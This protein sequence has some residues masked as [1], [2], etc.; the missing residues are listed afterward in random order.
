[1]NFLSKKSVLITGGGSGIGASFA[2]KF[3]SLQCK[4]WVVGRN[5][6]KLK[7]V[8]NLDENI[9]YF[10]CDVTDENQIIDLYDKIGSPDIIIANAGKAESSAFHKTTLNQCQNI[11]DVNLKWVLLE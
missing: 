4:V 5:K 8:S 2:K 10:I 6:N 7:E 9:N 11:I 1:M 3:V